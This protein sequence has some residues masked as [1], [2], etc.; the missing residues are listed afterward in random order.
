[1]VVGWR[2]SV[3]RGIRTPADTFL[4]NAALPLSYGDILSYGQFFACKVPDAHFFQDFLGLG[5]GFQP[6]QEVLNWLGV[7]TKVVSTKDLWLGVSV[8]SHQFY[9]QI[10]QDR[11]QVHLG[12]SSTRIKRP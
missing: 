12:Q 9:S 10:F 2:I 8:F 4:E 7:A 3:P 11:F 1:M 5:I 6:N